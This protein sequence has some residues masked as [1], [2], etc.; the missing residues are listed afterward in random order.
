M[1]LWCSIFMQR[2]DALRFA[3]NTSL[4]CYL[5]SN[6]LLSKYYSEISLK[7]KLQ[8]AGKY[9]IFYITGITGQLCFFICDPVIPQNKLGIFRDVINIAKAQCSKFNIGRIYVIASS[10]LIS[11]Y[12]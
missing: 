9:I 6:K 10:N 3:N 5:I 2:K 12:I 11:F 1:L 8:P 7:S 4:A